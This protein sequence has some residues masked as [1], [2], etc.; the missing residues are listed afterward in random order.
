MGAEKNNQNLL[1]GIQ[2]H[3]FTTNDKSFPYYSHS[4]SSE[5]NLKAWEYFVSN[6][7]GSE[8]IK[9]ILS[10]EN[11][12]VWTSVFKNGL[13]IAHHDISVAAEESK[14]LGYFGIYPASRSRIKINVTSEGDAAGVDA[15][16]RY[17]KKNIMTVG[18]DVELL[19][20]AEKVIYHGKLKDF[21]K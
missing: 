4:I 3:E 10:H 16:G 1:S 18:R 17:M 14:P 9:G 13:Y 6:I 21:G 7:D 19:L 5:P 2:A 12:L 11:F 20:H 8:S 15:I